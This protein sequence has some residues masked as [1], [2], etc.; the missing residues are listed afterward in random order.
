VRLLWLTVSHDSHAFGLSGEQHS[1][2]MY[3]RCSTHEAG[4]L[5]EIDSA[6]AL[7]ICSP[8]LLSESLVILALPSSFEK[9]L[10]SQARPLARS[11]S[12]LSTYTEKRLHGLLMR[13]QRPTQ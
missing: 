2:K 10:R 13:D 12:S 8:D 6:H 3:M 7:R 5:K 1:A 4:C 11:L 9:A